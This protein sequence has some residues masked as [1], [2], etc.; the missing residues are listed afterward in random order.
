MRL[1]VFTAEFPGRINTFFARDMAALVRAGVEIDVFPIYPLRARY[2]SAVPEYLNADVL[3]RNRVHHVSPLAGLRPT[4]TASWRRW[5]RFVADTARVRAAA[6]RFGPDA[7]VK[8]EYS[9]LKAWSWARETSEPYDHVLAY[10]GNYTATAA[11][12]FHRLL[13]GDDGDVPLSILLRATSI[14]PPEAALRRQHPR[15]MRVQPPLSRRAIP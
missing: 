2:W 10:W 11:Y 4:R 12:V 6:V 8:T 1:A 13:D 9:C 14:S 7:I 15:R 3:P 5:A